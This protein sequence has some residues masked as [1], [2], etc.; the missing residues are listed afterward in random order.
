MFYGF[1]TDLFPVLG[2]RPRPN[3]RQTGYVCGTPQKVHAKPENTPDIFQLLLGEQRD[4]QLVFYTVA[5]TQ[6]HLRHRISPW[7][8]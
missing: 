5:M 4:N 1:Y 6:C 2:I 8:T 7:R 3:R